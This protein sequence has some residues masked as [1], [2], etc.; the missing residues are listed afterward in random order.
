MLLDQKPKMVIKM[1]AK[2]VGCSALADPSDL[3]IELG[4][5]SEN[6]YMASHDVWKS[7]MVGKFNMHGGSS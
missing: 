6:F 4:K 2:S 1:L 5:L 3:C 7:N